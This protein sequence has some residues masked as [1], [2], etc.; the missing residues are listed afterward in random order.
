MREKLRKLYGAEAP[1]NTDLKHGI[2]TDV[3]AGAKG[4]QLSV[5]VAKQS[6]YMVSKLFSSITFGL[7][8]GISMNVR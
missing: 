4:L 1:I 6:A 5:Q 8:D 2:N 7:R 3:K